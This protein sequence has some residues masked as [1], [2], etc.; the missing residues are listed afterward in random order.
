M[1]FK[2]F[3]VSIS[4]VL[5]LESNLCAKIGGGREAGGGSRRLFGGRDSP[6]SVWGGTWREGGCLMF[7]WREVLSSEYSLSTDAS[8]LL[9]KSHGPG[10]CPTSN[11]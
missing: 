6:V 9:H 2:V 7:F 3:L 5:E 11:F 1:F 4:S 8:S 10:R